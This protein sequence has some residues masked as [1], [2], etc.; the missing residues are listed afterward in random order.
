[1]QCKTT[2]NR[3][4]LNRWCPG[5]DSNS[6]IFRYRLLRSKR[7]CPLD[8]YGRRYRGTI[9]LRTRCAH[10]PKPPNSAQKPTA[11]VEQSAE[12]SK[13]C[14]GQSKRLNPRLRG[15]RTFQMLLRAE[16]EAKPTPAWPHR[17]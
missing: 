14:L 11:S 2:P 9:T 5:R 10:R 7:N 8:T 4:I 1:M 3:F 12:L 6:D 15:C 13:C 16:Q 17:P